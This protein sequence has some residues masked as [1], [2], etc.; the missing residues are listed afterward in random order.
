MNGAIETAKKELESDDDERIKAAY[1]NL[2]N[3]VQPVFQK[4][5]QNAQGAAGT[6]PDMGGAN[7]GNDGDTEFHQ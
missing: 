3:A 1:D 7:G 5:Y 4:L 2:M 6:N